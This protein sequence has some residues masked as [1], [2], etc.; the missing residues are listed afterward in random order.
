MRQLRSHHLAAVQP[1]LFR[2][3]RAT[4]AGLKPHDRTLLQPH[5]FVKQITNN[6]LQFVLVAAGNNSSTVLATESRRAHNPYSLVE[7][8]LSSADSQVLDAAELAGAHDLEQPALRAGQ[9]T[10][11]GGRAPKVVQ[12]HT[13]GESAG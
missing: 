2:A 11:C 12:C 4:R 6:L 5:Q 9:V 10:S 8:R 3:G 13:H 1:L 7:G